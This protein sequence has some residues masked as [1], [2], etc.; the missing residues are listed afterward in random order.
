MVACEESNKVTRVPVRFPPFERFKS[1]DNISVWQVKTTTNGHRNGLTRKN[2]REKIHVK[3]GFEV[4]KWLLEITMCKRAN[5]FNYSVTTCDVLY[6]HVF[7]SFCEG[8]TQTARK[9]R[10]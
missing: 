4:E 9:R 1:N 10:N 8:V 7:L 2:K 3:I 5:D 6:A